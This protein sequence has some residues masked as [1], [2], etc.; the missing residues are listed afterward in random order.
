[1]KV[2][3]TPIL[4]TIGV[5]TFSDR[6]QKPPMKQKSRA[7]RSFFDRKRGENTAEQLANVQA[8]RVRLKQKYQDQTMN[9]VRGVLARVVHQADL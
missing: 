1:M 3:Q 9:L 5:Q 6:K 8:L 2:F 4:H 7:V